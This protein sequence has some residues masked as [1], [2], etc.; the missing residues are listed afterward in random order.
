MGCVSLTKPVWATQG[1]VFLTVRRLVFN[2]C[3]MDG[4]EDEWAG[5]RDEGGGGEVEG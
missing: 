2:K 5:E 1:S 3:Q 4:W